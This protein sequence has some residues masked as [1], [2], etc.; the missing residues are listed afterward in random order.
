MHIFLQNEHVIKIKQPTK[1]FMFA[2]EE[3][4]LLIKKQTILLYS[5]KLLI[6]ILQTT[7]PPY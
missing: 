1:L 7:V 5:K 3:V 2:T 6:S 4:F